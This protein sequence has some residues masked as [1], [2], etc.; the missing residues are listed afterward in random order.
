MEEFLQRLAQ[1]LEVD[2]VQGSS[3]LRDFAEWDSL[4][5][6]SVTAMVDSDYGVQLGANDLKKLG[7][8]QGLYDLVLERRGK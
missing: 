5:A 1:I 6:L 8:A 7:T 3:V 2:E 4:S